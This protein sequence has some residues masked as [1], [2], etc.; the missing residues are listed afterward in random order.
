V[1]C[2]AW[3]GTVRR[4]TIKIYTTGGETFTTEE[5]SGVH[6][7]RGN[8]WC[9]VPPSVIKK[10]HLASKERCVCREIIILLVWPNHFVEETYRAHCNRSF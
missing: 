5:T 1:W 6:S 4:S 9:L 3:W 10:F 7:D 8:V 2:L